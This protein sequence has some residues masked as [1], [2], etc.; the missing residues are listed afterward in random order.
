[1][2]P[3]SAVVVSTV[4]GDCKAKLTTVQLTG[5]APTTATADTSI[6][7]SAT[8]GV[9]NLILPANAT[10]RPPLLIPQDQSA[11]ELSRTGKIAVGVAVPLGVLLFALL[12]LFW[13]RLHRRKKA[14]MLKILRQKQGQGPPGDQPIGQ[15]D[16]TFVKA[17]LEAEYGAA[18]TG[19]GGVAFQKPELDHNAAVA[20]QELAVVGDTLEL[21]NGQHS[22]PSELDSMMQS[23]P[24]NTEIHNASRPAQAPLVA[25]APAATTVNETVDAHY[26]HN[27]PWRWS[28]PLFAQ[29]AQPIERHPP[30]MP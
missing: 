8:A 1:M 24:S 25:T 22:Y 2:P 23:A 10:F 15:T 3:T 5:I 19:S 12:V 16:T 17:E 27:E 11:P 26:Q 28:Q 21:D 14:R 18:V 9:L 13:R 20:R 30:K 6:F 29:G 4:D 7:P